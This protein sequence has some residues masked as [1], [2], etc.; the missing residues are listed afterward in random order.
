ME[1]DWRAREQ[2]ARHDKLNQL[3]KT[4]G[5][6]GLYQNKTRKEGL[7]DVVVDAPHAPAGGRIVDP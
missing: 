5:E 7:S 3:G 4:K 6:N 1:D 2:Q